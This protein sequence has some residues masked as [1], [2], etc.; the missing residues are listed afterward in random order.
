MTLRTLMLLAATAMVVVLA[1]C[2]SSHKE[3]QRGS[4]GSSPNDSITFSRTTEAANS[5]IYV[6]DEEGAHETRLTHTKQYEYGPVWSPDGQKI[7]Y[8]RGDYG[9]LYVM[10]ADGTNQT[11][12]PGAAPDGWVPAWS[13]DGKKIAFT[14]GGNVYLISINANG[15]NEARITTLNG[16]PEEET[17]PKE[18]TKLGSP[19]WSPDGKKIAFISLS[20]TIADPDPSDT[21]SSA[22]ASATV[23]AEELTG[24][25]LINA[26]GTGLRKLTSIAQVDR[27][28]WSP[29]GKKMFFYEGSAIYVI[30]TD[31]SDRKELTSGTNIPPQFALSPD[32][33]RIAFVDT[34]NELNVINADGSGLR[35]LTHSPGPSSVA[36]PTWSP[37]SEKLAYSCPFEDPLHAHTDLCVINADGTGMKRI[38]SKVAPEGIQVAASWAR[39]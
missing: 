25:Y 23:P 9:K 3:D 14:G 28:A 30:N 37:D 18:E 2:G 33:K 15:T 34:S 5:D 8:S 4:Q 17:N 12:L 7:A 16:N 10:N 24:I 13:P 35:R 31:G 29:D 27:P 1:G 39:E 19:V 11:R 36:L 26:D 22:S 32:G 21:E 38:A 20:Y 6:I